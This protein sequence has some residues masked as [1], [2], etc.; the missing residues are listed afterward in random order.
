LIA[1][2]GGSVG[3]ESTPGV[4][5]TFW[6]LLPLKPAAEPEETPSDVEI[7]RVPPLKGHILVVDDNP[8]NQIVTVRAVGSLGYVTAVVSGGKE[9]I[10]AVKREGFDAVLMDCQMPEVDGYTAAAEIRRLEAEA[11]DD[12]RVP[13]IAMTANA[14][15]GDQERC[16][17]AGM[18]DYL[19]KP[20]RI[21]ILE[22]TLKR[23]SCERGR[24]KARR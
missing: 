23:W 3:V 2:M 18:D 6:F 22:E 14:V 20:I 1:L 21:S 10:E 7:N 15:E 17:A 4:G 9:A 8:V 16:I 11:R 5:S 12:R 24:S 13:I 19:T